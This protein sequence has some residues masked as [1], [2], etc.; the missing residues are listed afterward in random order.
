MKRTSIAFALLFALVAAP[1]HGDSAGDVWTSYLDYAYVYSAA[2]RDALAARLE[3]YGDE[4]GRSLGDYVAERFE[5]SRTVT[6][7]S[8]PMEI[9][10]M[11]VAYLLEYLSSGEP[12]LYFGLGAA[13]RV[14]VCGKVEPLS[15]P[16]AAQFRCMVG[17]Q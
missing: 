17:R 16:S 2:E 5:A 15:N 6:E 11:A 10:R 3:S 9:R 13:A 8:E 4:A 7:D 14:R 12:R 1:A